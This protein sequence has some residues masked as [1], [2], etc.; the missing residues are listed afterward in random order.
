VDLPL[1]PQVPRDA[2]RSFIE[3][4]ASLG[5]KGKLT[6]NAAKLAIA[7][8]SKLAA[9]GHDPAQV[10]AQS[11]LNNWRGLFPPKAGNGHATTATP[12]KPRF[13][14]Q[15]CTGC[16]GTRFIPNDAGTQGD[17]YFCQG[18]EEIQRQTE[19]RK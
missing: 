9:A 3:H 18:C 8:L 19:A 10:I 14:R 1:P 4:R 17:W 6:P 2:W 12:D 11:V 7:E 16:C 15:T 13:K 5:A